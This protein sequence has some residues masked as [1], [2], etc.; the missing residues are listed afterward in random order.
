ME[1]KKKVTLITPSE[2][3]AKGLIN[4]FSDLGEFTVEEFLKDISRTSEAILKNIDSDV[5]ILDP[6][7]L[8]FQSRKEGRNILS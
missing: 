7:V 3:I 5:I 2:L 4:I 1:S 6:M 8:D